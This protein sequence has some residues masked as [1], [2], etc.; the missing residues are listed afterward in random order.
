M[1]GDKARTLSLAAAA[2]GSADHEF[3]GRPC[4][5]HRI[6]SRRREKNTVSECYMACWN[7]SNSHHWVAA[8]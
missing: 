2:E 8:S 6:S 5:K 4:L 1:G 7:Y 3:D